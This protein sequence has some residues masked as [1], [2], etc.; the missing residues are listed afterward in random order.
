VVFGRIQQN[1]WTAPLKLSISIVNDIQAGAVTHI[2][3]SP[4]DTIGT[5]LAAF[6]SGVVK[7]WQSSI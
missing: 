5:F 2:A 1:A 3:F 7:Q 4:H 6:D